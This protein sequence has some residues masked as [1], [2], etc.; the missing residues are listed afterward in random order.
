MLLL[1]LVATASGEV[2]RFQGTRGLSDALVQDINAT[3]AP[4]EIDSSDEEGI[5]SEEE[6]T[7]GDITSEEEE[8]DDT[9]TE[10]LSFF[11]NGKQA[12]KITF[13]YH[14]F[15]DADFSALKAPA[16]GIYQALS[17][18]TDLYLTSILQEGLGKVVY[19]SLKMTDFT[20][21]LSVADTPLSITF[22]VEA[23]EET[24][25]ANKEP[26]QVDPVA[27]IQAAD[28]AEYREYI[29]GY[30]WNTY[31]I[32]SDDTALLRQI[33]KISYDATVR[34]Q[35]EPTLYD[36]TVCPALSIVASTWHIGF[37][38][39]VFV[40]DPTPADFIALACQMYAYVAEVLIEVYHGTNVDTVLQNVYW[41]FYAPD[42]RGFVL[43]VTVDIRAQVHHANG[44]KTPV[45]SAYISDILVN[46]NLHKFITQYMHKEEYWQHTQKL[47][48]DASIKDV[49]AG[50]Q[51]NWE[52]NGNEGCPAV[53]P[54]PTRTP[55]TPRPTRTPI[56]PRPT[57]PHVTTPS[58]VQ[59]PVPPPAPAPEPNAP[60]PTPPPV[61]RA[62][63][64]SVDVQTHPPTPYPTQA[65]RPNPNGPA[66]NPPPPNNNYNPPNPPPGQQ[67]NAVADYSGSQIDGA[68]LDQCREA[69]FMADVDGNRH[70]NAAEY[71]RLLNMMG[72]QAYDGYPFVALP[73]E[74]KNNFESWA[75]EEAEYQ[76]ELEAMMYPNA[77]N[78]LEQQQL[79]RDAVCRGTNSALLQAAATEHPS[80]VR[81]QISKS[82]VA[83][84]SE[85]ATD[86][87]KHDMEEV[88]SRFLVD[89]VA[90]RILAILK[91]NRR[92]RQRKLSQTRYWVMPDSAA[93]DAAQ[94]MECP[95][96]AP[97]GASCV[98][99]KAE[100]EVFVLTP[101]TDDPTDVN[102]IEKAAEQATDEGV[103]D[104]KLQDSLDRYD[105]NSPWS[106]VSDKNLPPAGTEPPKRKPGLGVESPDLDRDT[107]LSIVYVD[108]DTMDGVI[109]RGNATKHI[110]ETQC[111]GEAGES[112]LDAAG[113]ACDSFTGRHIWHIA[114]G[115][116][117]A[118]VLLIV[119]L[120]LLIWGRY[121]CCGG[122][123]KTAATTVASRIPGRRNKKNR[124][125]VFLEPPGSR[126][127]GARGAYA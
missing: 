25:D 52:S 75:S 20:F 95:E 48:I 78:P 31:P 40:P 15:T 38:Q 58:P 34:G 64:G 68:F 76:I 24:F 126:G 21:D 108:D 124:G 117:L 36:T 77:D 10:M 127:R 59:T 51:P 114:V 92:L 43:D 53:T 103:E 56:T 44:K 115:I 87:P 82:F 110:S 116:G 112:A 13:D 89:Y 72:N 67:G 93:I 84:N 105:P 9:G 97:N 57:Q 66:S 62:Q 49:A 32:G 125:D 70:I 55:I 80:P 69:L 74:L 8:G 29:M 104:G 42:S 101:N 100:Y 118:V 7:E 98:Q 17:C 39:D 96:G 28:S 46:A 119:F 30:A 81:L 79:H 123:Q 5:T 14:F 12:A 19:L 37:F 1:G 106:F 94:Q 91:G 4:T 54:P 61:G 26:V 122:Y 83:Y 47:K 85:G 71:V 41:Q 88:L 50:I 11:A 63:E 65:P 121:P 113:I 102:A 33:N 45:P 60:P 73:M 99:P 35:T 111:G 3:S 86:F 107:G 109:V 6:G 22:Y 90:D 120:P 27:I 23:H 16:L 18:Q 2:L